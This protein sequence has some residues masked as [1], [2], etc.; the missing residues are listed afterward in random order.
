MEKL[1][2]V[3][4]GAVNGVIRFFN[5]ILDWFRETNW[6]SQGKALEQAEAAKREAQLTRET[7]EILSEDRTKEDTTKRL[8]DG[9][10]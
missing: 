8:E 1:W 9:T 6:I 7:S 4:L 2:A 3:I 10:F 5:G